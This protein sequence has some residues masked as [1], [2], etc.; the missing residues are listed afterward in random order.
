MLSFVFQLN[1]SVKTKIAKPCFGR[2]PQSLFPI[3]F[4]IHDRQHISFRIKPRRNH[5]HH[6]RHENDRDCKVG[7]NAVRFLDQRQQAELGDE[8][9]CDAASEG[10]EDLGASDFAAVLEGLG[11]LDEDCDIGKLEGSVEECG[12][13]ALPNG[14][15]AVFMVFTVSPIFPA[16]AM[17][18]GT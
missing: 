12:V 5:M 18:F 16:P 15:S 9:V 2:T 10:G 8:E 17:M 7:E 4:M 14:R 13:Q 1:L 11:I 6:I 3:Y